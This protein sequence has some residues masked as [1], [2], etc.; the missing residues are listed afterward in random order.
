MAFRKYR[1]TKNIALGQLRRT[2]HTGDIVEYDGLVTRIAGQEYTLPTM[3][4]VLSHKWLILVEEERADIVQVEATTVSYLTPVLPA[5]PPSAS[6][7]NAHGDRITFASPEAKSANGRR[8]KANAQHVWD[9][10]SPTH[11]PSWLNNLNGRT[12]VVCGVTET[13]NIRV[14]RQRADGRKVFSYEDAHGKKITSFE[15]LS[16]PTYIGDAESAAAIAKDHI[17][18]VRGRVDD[19]EDRLETVD[20]RLTRMEADNDFLRQRLLDRPILNAEMVAEALILLATKSADRPGLAE[21]VRALLP[22][23]LPIEEEWVSVD[24]GDLLLVEV[25]HSADT[26]D[27]RNR[28]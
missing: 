22:A 21:Q 11:Q 10:D 4:E 8:P 28:S 26:D 25:D 16:C 1:A 5:P 17:R 15:E 14:D 7:V 19:V 24:E 13:Q 2:L 6:D 3:D 12:C 18:R 23:P 20:D 9:S 27:L